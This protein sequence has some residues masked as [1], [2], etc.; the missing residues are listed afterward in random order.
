MKKLKLTNNIKSVMA[1]MVVMA[2]ALFAFAFRAMLFQ[3]GSGD[4]QNI[5]GFVARDPLGG[6]WMGEEFAL[7][8]V[9]GVMVENH[10][11][12]RPQAG[13]D[14]A[15][16]V[17]EAPVEARISRMLAFFS[18]WQTV[19]KIGPVRS[20][21]PYYIDWN[22]EL[23][24][25]YAH[26]GGSPAAL[27]ILQTDDTIN[28]DEYSNENFFWRE[29]MEREA[30]HNVYTS[31]ELLQ[32]AYGSFVSRFGDEENNWQ[33]WKFKDHAVEAPVD[34]KSVSIDFAGEPY[35]VEWVFESDGM[36]YR[37]Y[38]GG[39]PHEMENGSVIYAN[40]IVVVDA[41]VKILDSVGRRDV[42]TI[43]EGDA[44]L[45]QDGLVIEATWKKP[46]RNTR[47]RFYDRTSGEEL[48]MNAGRTW[49]EVVSDMDNYVSIKSGKSIWE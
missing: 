47:L 8:R 33:S 12:S 31:M 5:S 4:D 14:Q 43:G 49:V 19:P 44:L 35:M 46:S 17:I 10:I 37:R 22:A 13:L 16:L 23:D 48:A 21:R 29:D 18:E 3:Q 41:D 36:I 7:P 40:N 15:S 39:T 27:E 42:Q 6:G 38:Q 26:V 24:A 32:K 1:I 28:I 9:Y 25:V 34:A 45:F 2:I 11:D 30:P 20:A